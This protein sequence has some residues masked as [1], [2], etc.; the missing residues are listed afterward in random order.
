MT[1][2][3]NSGVATSNQRGMAL[4]LALL[5]V[6]LVTVIAVELSWR[7]ELTLSRSANR[8]HGV[9]AD[10]YLLGGEALAHWIL[11]QDTEKDQQEGIVNDTLQ[12][13]W[14]QPAQMPTDEGWLRGTVTD[15]QGRFNLNSLIDKAPKL[16]GNKT[17]QSWQK[18]TAP[19][20][21][22]IRLLQTI[23]LEEDVFLDQAAAINIT[24]AIMDWVDLDSNVSTISGY[25]GA[26]SD[27]YGQLD[28]PF[29]VANKAMMS[30]T[31]LNVI[32]GITPV[33]YR[34]LLPLVIALPKE[35]PIN[36]NTMPIQLMRTIND[37]KIL[38]PNN[39]DDAQYI[40]EERSI[41]YEDIASFKSSAAVDQV[42][43]STPN[44]ESNIDITGLDIKSSYFIFVGDT[45]VG[46]HIRERKALMFRDGSK[47]TTLRRTDANF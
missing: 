14:A 25:G 11:T 4:I 28:P 3:K 10:A 18:W 40:F 6:A 47:V 44:G 34:K 32:R 7:F 5:V 29:V 33:L 37:K 15:A 8:W 16:Q 30:V 26:E 31:E 42:V 24:E 9:Q 36:V 35:V 13:E 39:I 45:S 38:Y 41:G 22:F 43:G 17:P 2:A 27:Y 1:R 21:R 19:Q 23:E 46:D 12:E 20:R